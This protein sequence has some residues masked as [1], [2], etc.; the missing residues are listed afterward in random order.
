MTALAIFGS[1]TST[2]L[3][4]RGRS[5]TTD[6]PIPSGTNWEPLSLAATWITGARGS[7]AGAR[8]VAANPKAV[9]NATSSAVRI[10]DV[11]PMFHPPCRR[12]SFR[13]RRGGDAEA[14][15]VETAACAFVGDRF[16]RA[17]ALEIDQAA[18]RQR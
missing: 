1:A 18:Q 16:G 8:P 17:P 6:V 5:I 3:M 9:I 11:F 7:A 12:A 2:S 13:N 14:N 15:Y 4:S 10:S